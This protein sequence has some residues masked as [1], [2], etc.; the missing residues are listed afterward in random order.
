MKLLVILLAALLTLST[1]TTHARATTVFMPAATGDQRETRH[2]GAEAGNPKPL[3]LT[4]PA[5]PTN[6]VAPWAVMS[7]V[8]ALTGAKRVHKV[9]MSNH[10]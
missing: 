8:L 5:A 6:G 7:V 3:A 1:A 10:L 9:R 2:A 4:A